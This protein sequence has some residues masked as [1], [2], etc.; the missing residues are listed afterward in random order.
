MRSR[1]K[2]EVLRRGTLG[3]ATL[4]VL[5]AVAYLPRGL[6]AQSLEADTPDLTGIWGR[7]GLVK[8]PDPMRLTA[9]A[10]GFSQAFDE[11][12]SPRYDCSPVA[13]PFIIRDPY[14]FAIEQQSDRVILRYEKDDVTRT[15]WLEGYGHAEPGPYGFTIQG[16]STGRYEGDQF[17]VETTQFTFD[18]I[19]LANT[20]II[21][22]STLKRVIERYWR[23][24]DRLM[25]NVITED[26]LILREPY[27]FTFEWERTELGLITYGCD[28][29]LARFPAQ[30]QPSK[31]QDP[32]WVRLPATEIGVNR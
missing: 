21:P 10:I 18:P 32:G 24:G 8:S 17:V 22:S 26:P 11:A 28:P 27:E 20:G 14:N 12:L 31:Y 25:V 7:Q 5:L 1:I 30:F 16:H 2:T 23:N 29:E 15:I 19:G 3:A 6:N 9:R 13:L 4:T